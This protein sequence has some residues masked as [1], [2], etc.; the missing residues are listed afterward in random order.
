MIQIHLDK[1][2]SSGFDHWNNFY[3]KPISGKL[4]MHSSLPIAK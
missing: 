3:K 1:L 2:S 4:L